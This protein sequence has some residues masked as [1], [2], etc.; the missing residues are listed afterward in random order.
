[1]HT[2]WLT[3][4][5][6]SGQNDKSHD[7]LLFPAYE[8]SILITIFEVFEYQY[9]NMSVVRENEQPLTKPWSDSFYNHVLIIVTI[10][11]YLKVK[12]HLIINF[13]QSF[14]LRVMH[15]VEGI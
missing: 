12:Q 2:L 7:T 9:L 13:A 15:F 6:T 11:V 10:S 3:R 8:L 14:F 1:M 5:Y 4:K